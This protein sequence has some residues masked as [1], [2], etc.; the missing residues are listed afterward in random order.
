MAVKLGDRDDVD[1]VFETIVAA[2]PGAAAEIEQAGPGSTVESL[3]TTLLFLSLT[4]AAVAVVNLVGTAVLNVGE[5]RRD[6][7]VLK[8]LG[9]TPR[10]VLSTVATGNAVL[11]AVAGVVGLAVGLA[12]LRI[13]LAI[14]GIELGT[15]PDFGSLPHW[16]E[17]VLLVVAAVAVTTGATLVAGRRAAAINAADA[18]RYE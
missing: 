10:Q 3:Q 18:L 8:A 17:S 9:F 6:I 15:G 11:G 5:H 2:A 4:L 1:S 14:V 7:G 16:W 12:G 13:V